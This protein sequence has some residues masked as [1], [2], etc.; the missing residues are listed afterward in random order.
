MIKDFEVANVKTSTTSRLLHQ[1]KYRVYDP[2]AISN[3]IA[4][5]QKTWLSDR[6]VNTK[7]ASAQVLIDHLTVS[8]DTS[9]VFL[10]HDPETP[11]TG[12]AKKGRP[13]KSSPMRAATKDFN[14]QVVETEIIPEISADQYATAPR[15]ALY[16]PESDCILLYVAGII[17]KELHITIMFPELLAVDNTGGTTIDERMLMIVA[18]L[19]NTRRKFPSLRAFLPSECQWVFIFSFSYVFPKLLG[20]GTVRRITQVCPIVTHLSQ[21]LFSNVAQ[22][23]ICRP[24][25]TE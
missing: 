11:L 4:K 25:P 7:A 18:G 8:P 19:D 3:I 20:Q 10:L 16:L 21:H 12:G 24:M 22:P 1:M 6:G 5:A 13:K 14:S 23:I 2:K 9:C 17:N 15:E